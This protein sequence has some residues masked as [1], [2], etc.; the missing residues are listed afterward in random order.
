MSDD[1]LPQGYSQPTPAADG[2]AMLPPL[3][4]AVSSAA[5]IAAEAWAAALKQRT[6][7]PCVMPP[8][9]EIT[10]FQT[11]KVSYI[12]LDVNGKGQLCN[13]DPQRIGIMFGSNTPVNICPDAALLAR[14]DGGIPLTVLSTGIPFIYINH[15]KMPGLPQVAWFANF[16]TMNQT[17]TVIEIVLREWP[18]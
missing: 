9:D 14:A 15:D 13:S 11:P 5:K 18:R 6:K 1:F 17:V 12:T 4:G 7:P 16:G 3:S 8:W 2:S 10:Y